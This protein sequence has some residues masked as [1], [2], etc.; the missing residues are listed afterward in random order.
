MPEEATGVG[1]PGTGLTCGC[2]LPGNP[3][4][5]LGRAINVLHCWA[6]SP[7]LVLS[8][9]ERVHGELQVLKQY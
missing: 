6:V 5:A 8:I 7:T 4:L 3:T 1:F 9:S 2:E